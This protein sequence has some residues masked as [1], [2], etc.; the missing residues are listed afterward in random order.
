MRRPHDSAS[1]CVSHGTDLR[2]LFDSLAESSTPATAAD[3]IAR[4]ALSRP[5]NLMKFTPTTA[6]DSAVSGPPLDPGSIGAVCWMSEI[7]WPCD[8]A[9][10]RSFETCPRV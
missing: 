5:V 3:G 2:P 6:P 4:Y 1:R 8:V 7:V 10:K 9:A